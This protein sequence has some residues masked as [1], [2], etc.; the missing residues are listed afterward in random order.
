VTALSLVNHRHQLVEVDKERGE[1]GDARCNGRPETLGKRDACACGAEFC[2]RHKFARLVER[3]PGIHA[4]A[5]V[6][7][8]HGLSDFF[9]RRWP[10][11]RR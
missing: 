9:L 1:I 7:R 10:A 8:A 2:L 5:V 4:L 6:D 11:H 3:V